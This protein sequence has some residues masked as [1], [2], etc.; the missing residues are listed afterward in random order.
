M[1]LV[2]VALLAGGGELLVRG[3]VRLARSL[4]VA[5]VVVGL[6]VVAFGNSSP[7]LF[8]NLGEPPW[9]Q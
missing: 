7:E 2:G 5:P 3:S 6:T 1:V 4:R 8:T 9:V